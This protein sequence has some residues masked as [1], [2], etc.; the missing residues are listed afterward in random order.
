MEEETTK[1]QDLEKRMKR[2][3]NIHIWGVGIIV[4][5]LFIF[6]LINKKKGADVGGVIETPTPNLPV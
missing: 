2:I 1:L 5:G 6:F 3:E 4:V